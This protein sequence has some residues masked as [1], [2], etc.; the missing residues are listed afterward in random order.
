MFGKKLLLLADN[1]P[2]VEEKEELWESSR[3]KLH[4]RKNLKGGSNSNKNHNKEPQDL[5]LLLPFSTQK[6]PPCQSCFP[7][8]G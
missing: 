7:A 3:S 8:C 5:P 6:T 2:A 4:K 1:K